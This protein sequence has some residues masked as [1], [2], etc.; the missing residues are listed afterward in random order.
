MQR[1]P[2]RK[3]GTTRHLNLGSI[4]DGGA[5]TPYNRRPEPVHHHNEFTSDQQCSSTIRLT[6]A[7]LVISVLIFSK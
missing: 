4:G 7:S 5:A 3:K 1:L 2:Y 6:S